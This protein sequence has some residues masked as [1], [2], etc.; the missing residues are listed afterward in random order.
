M[1]AVPS[2]ERKYEEGK[3][4][5]RKELEKMEEETFPPY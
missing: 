2:I 4:T 5:V 1:L 3:E